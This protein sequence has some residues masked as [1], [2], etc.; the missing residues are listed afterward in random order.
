MKLSVS[1]RDLQPPV[2]FKLLHIYMPTAPLITLASS[3]STC[4]T[5]N[6]WS[7]AGNITW[8]CRRYWSYCWCRF[9]ILYFCYY[10]C[11]S[12][13][14]LCSNMWQSSPNCW[15]TAGNITWKCRRKCRRYWSYCWWLR[16]CRRKCRR[17]WS[18][19]WWRLRRCRFWSLKRC[20]SS[21]RVSSVLYFCYYICNSFFHPCS[22]IWQSSIWCSINCWSFSCRSYGCTS[23]GCS[24]LCCCDFTSISFNP[25][26]LYVRMSK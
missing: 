1:R 13:F 2:L 23:C 3:L 4:T 5:P 17:Y 19:C 6:C 22:N 8:K 9:F 25:I 12:F 11:N 20:R 16:R 15:S 14:H 24:R 7:T 18:Y 26:N 21:C 10:I